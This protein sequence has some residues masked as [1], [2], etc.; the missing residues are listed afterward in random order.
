MTSTLSP[1]ELNEKWRKDFYGIRK[2]FY[3]MLDASMFNSHYTLIYVTILFWMLSFVLFVW[4][5]RLCCKVRQRLNLS[6]RL[7]P[8]NIVINLC[9]WALALLFRWGEERSS[10]RSLLSDREPSAALD[11]LALSPASRGP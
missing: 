9:I 11:R 6:W 7:S 8:A 2:D 3:W 10:L 5:M 4:G 1:A